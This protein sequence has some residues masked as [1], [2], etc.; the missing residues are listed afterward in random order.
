ML[1]RGLSTMLT[2]GLANILIACAESA[3]A[4]GLSLFAIAAPVLA[5][6]AV[7]VMLLIMAIRAVIARSRREAHRG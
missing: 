6:V 4:L 3:F 2:G 5:G 1:T 7:L